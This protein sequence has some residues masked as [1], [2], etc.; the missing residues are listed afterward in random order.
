MLL[1]PRSQARTLA[2]QALCLFD[3]LGEQFA[4]QLA[5]FL[6]DSHVYADLGLPAAPPTDTLAFARELATGTWQNRQR[7]DELLGKLA[8]DWSIERMPRVDHNT[9]RLGLHELHEHPE[10]PPEVVINEAIELAR[11]L[12]SEDSPRFVNAV[13]DAGRRM[14]GIDTARDASKPASPPD[15]LGA[16]HTP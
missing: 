12:G 14:L 5:D 7:Y 8:T 3:S 6:H 15:S 9:L 11:R 1:T 13:L 2:L 4:D 10:T 16:N